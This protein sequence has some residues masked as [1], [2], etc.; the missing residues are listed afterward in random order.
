MES[1]SDIKVLAVQSEVIQPCN[2]INCSQTIQEVRTSHAESACVAAREA[3]SYP[4]MSITF[5]QA[6]CSLCSHQ[7]S[8]SRHSKVWELGKTSRECGVCIRNDNSFLL[9]NHLTYVNEVLVLST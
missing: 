3:K 9:T 8:N 1:K 2:T 4:N 7:P 6:D 5:Y